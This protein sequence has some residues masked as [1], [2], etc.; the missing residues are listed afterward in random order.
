MRLYKKL[1]C[2]P[3]H[4]TEDLEK[5]ATKLRNLANKK[6]MKVLSKKEM[7]VCAIAIALDLTQPTASHHLNILENVKL[8]KSMKKGKW[9]FYSVSRSNRFRNLFNFLEIPD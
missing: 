2:L 3:L 7:C 5:Y 1:F 9:V 6:M 8:V 4:P